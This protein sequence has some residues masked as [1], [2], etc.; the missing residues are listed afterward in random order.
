M[1]VADTDVVSYLFKRHPLAEAYVG[2]LGGHSVLVSFMTVAEIEYGM[3]SDGWG[4]HRRASMRRYLDERFSVIYPDL[5]TVKI[6]ASIVAGCE[7]KGRSIAH[8][9]AWIAATALRLSVPLV[10]HNARD[11][12]AV[13][14]L[15]LFTQQRE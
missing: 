15:L 12:S 10:T 5:E 1:V 2:L 13:D 8:S 14:E 6:W 7:R 11:Y 9:D 3:E 4:G